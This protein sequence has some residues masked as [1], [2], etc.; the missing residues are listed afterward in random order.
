MRGTL[1]NNDI[2][3]KEVHRDS[4]ITI[5]IALFKLSEKY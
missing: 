4:M 3:S 5:T 2:I 1:G